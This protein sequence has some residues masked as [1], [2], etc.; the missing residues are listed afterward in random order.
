MNPQNEYYTSNYDLSKF[1]S[2]FLGAGVRLAPPNGIF[3]MQ[4]FN[5][6]ELRYGHYTRSIAMNANIITMNIKLK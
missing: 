1:N 6:I 4:H 5:M 3:G 2:N